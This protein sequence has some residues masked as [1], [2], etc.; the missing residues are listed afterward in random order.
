ME[1][2]KPNFE[3]ESDC[4][5]DRIKGDLKFQMPLIVSPSKSNNLQEYFDNNKNI[6]LDELHQSGAILFRDWDVDS[7][8]DFFE[9][10]NTLSDET[11]KYTQ[12]TSPRSEVI[13]KIYTSTDY[14]YDQEIKPHAESSYAPTWPLIIAFF[15]SIEPG[16]GGET[17]ITNNQEMLKKLKDSTLKMF[18]EKGISYTRNMIN[19]LGLP[20]QEV[21]QTDDKRKVEELLINDGMNFDWVDDDHL[22]IEWKRP[23]FQTHPVLNS[24]VWFN[25]SF[26]YHRMNQDPGLIDLVDKEDLPFRVSFGDK[27]E[28]SDET[29]QEFEQ[30]YKDATIAFK[31]QKGDLLLL[32]N[33]L[34]SH[35][36]RPFKGDRKI[37][38]SM[39]KPLKY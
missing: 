21:Y 37:L 9:V 2:T 7:A 4:V 3:T 23:A 10:I 13:N 12:R 28:I 22:R 29:F 17:P 11:L 20:W 32:D 1:T 39:A 30:A 25:H 8:E 19:W 27:S 6:I 35:A 36:R 14:P 38:V 16:E 26:F 34:F 15:C 18:S 31:W 33:M 5:T 24:K